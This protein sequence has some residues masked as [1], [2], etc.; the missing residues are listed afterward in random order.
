MKQ[1]HGFTGKRLVGAG[2]IALGLLFS[3]FALANILSGSSTTNVSN[4]VAYTAL[5]LSKPSTAVAGDVLLANVSV[6]GGSPAVITAPTG[7]VSIARTDNDT[8]ISVASY[9][10]VVS[11]SEPTSYTWTISPQTHAVG[12]ITDYTGVDT[13]NPIDAVGS[14]TGRGAVLT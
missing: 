2:L 12:G 6:N 14:S 4:D 3:S 5:S 1:P 11:G 10:K 8:N 13:T 9:Y 7:W